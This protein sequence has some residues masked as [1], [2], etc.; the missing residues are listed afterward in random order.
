MA[1]DQDELQALAQHRLDSALVA[2]LHPQHVRHQAVDAVAAALL[3]LAEHDRLHPATVALEV[4]LQLQERGQ[5]AAPIGQ[6]L[7]QL[8][9][10]RL[11]LALIGPAGRQVLLAHRF[12]L[13]ELLA[14]ALALEQL[15]R[16]LVALPRDLLRPRLQLLLLVRRLLQPAGEIAAPLL[17]IDQVGAVVGEA[18]EHAHRLVPLGLHRVLRVVDLLQRSLQ[19]LVLGAGVGQ[20][21]LL[22]AQALLLAPEQLQPHRQQRDFLLALHLPRRDRLPLALRE[23]H[24]L[25]VQPQLLVEAVRMLGQLLHL[26]LV[27]EKLQPLRGE[28]GLQARRMRLGHLLRFRCLGQL[29]RLRGLLLFE[30]DVLSAGREQLQLA[31]L[32]AQLA[33][34]FRPLCRALQRLQALLHF[35]HHVAEPQ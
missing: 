25:L 2:R 21:L 19:G 24:L 18:G 5:P 29:V 7:A 16:Q 27:L 6:L 17:Q 9:Q 8:D 35:A 15:L 34:P 26:L 28:S 13:V 22:D 23:L 30:P 20:L 14:A 32:A 1:L 12:L 4:L 3:L 10:R 31:Q 33:E 11:G